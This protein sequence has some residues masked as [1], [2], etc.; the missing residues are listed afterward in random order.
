MQ[1]AQG[2]GAWRNI[3]HKKA[4]YSDSTYPSIYN[5]DGDHVSFDEKA[6]ITY[7]G[8]AVYTVRVGEDIRCGQTADRVTQFL[9]D[10]GVDCSKFE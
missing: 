6:T 1:G 4:E 2:Q 5:A 9:A 8:C 10:R 3:L 7:R